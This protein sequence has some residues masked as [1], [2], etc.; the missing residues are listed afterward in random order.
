MPCQSNWNAKYAVA[1]LKFH[2]L[3]RIP[4]DTVRGSAS[5]RIMQAINLM[6]FKI[7]K[8]VGRSFTYHLL[9]HSAVRESIVPKNATTK[10]LNEKRPVSALIAVNLLGL[11]SHHLVFAAHGNARLLE[12]IRHTG[13]EERSNYVSASGAVK[14]FG[15]SHLRSLEEVPSS[16]QRSVMGMLKLF[17]IFPLLDSMFLLLGS[18]FAFAYLNVIKIGASRAVSLARDFIS[19]ISNINEMEEMRMTVTF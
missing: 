7:E 14:N 11:S 8:C 1:N 5:M 4:Q 10:D 2:R 18:A 16:V 12:E 3:G 15:Q 17:P 6:A 19:T 9:T 13:S